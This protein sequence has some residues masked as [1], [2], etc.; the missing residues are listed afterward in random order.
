MLVSDIQQKEIVVALQTE[1]HRRYQAP[2]VNNYSTTGI[3]SYVTNN[4]YRMEKIECTGGKR[5]VTCAE[6]PW[7]ACTAAQ[8]HSCAQNRQ[9]QELY[10]CRCDNKCTKCPVQ[11]ARPR[12]DK[13]VASRRI[14]WCELGTTGCATNDCCWLH[15]QQNTRH[16]QHHVRHA[17]AITWQQV[18][19]RQASN[20]RQGEPKKRGHKL[21]AIILSTL[22]RFSKLFYWEIP[23][24][25]W[26][27]YCYKTKTM[28]KTTKLC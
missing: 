7:S 15:Q 25:A 1:W 17:L 21:M 12:R 23:L 2:S 6:N 18:L 8:G 11:T 26:P 14:G 3:G 10:W 4:K 5:S 27:Q 24:C 19:D 9:E 20:T 22:N 13:T 28:H 16:V